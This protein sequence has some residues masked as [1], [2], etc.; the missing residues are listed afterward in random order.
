[1]LSV[2]AYA[3]LIVL[4]DAIFLS[5]ISGPFGNMIKKIQGEKMVLKLAPAIVVYL[6]M[7]GAWY[8]FIHK[9]VQRHTFT[10]NVCRAGLLGFFIYSVFDFTNLATIKNYELKIAVMDSVWGGLLYASTTAIL[11]YFTNTYKKN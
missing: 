6:S 9:E 2:L 8:L 4:V 3:I 11:L 7:I 10:E 1:M 5:Y